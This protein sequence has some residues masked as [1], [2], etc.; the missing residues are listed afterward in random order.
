MERRIASLVGQA[1]VE[2]GT[3][4]RPHV[5]HVESALGR[6]RLRVRLRVRVTVRVTVRVRVTVSP[7]TNTLSLSLSHMS[8]TWRALRVRG[9]AR[10]GKA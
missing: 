1:L 4:Q 9:C 7:N 6:V 3:A 8:A 10:Q 5:R 2:G